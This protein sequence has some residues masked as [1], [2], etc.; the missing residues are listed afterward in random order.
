MN[1]LMV[2]W[3]NK[4]R[5]SPKK[6]NKKAVRA[7]VW[8]ASLEGSSCPACHGTGYVT[9]ERDAHRS[10][11]TIPCPRGYFHGHGVPTCQEGTL[12]FSD[13]DKKHWPR[14]RKKIVT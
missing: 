1:D 7:S 6:N 9:M 4:L 8:D 5:R 3:A 11:G 14:N 10:G 13:Y 12:R 2:T